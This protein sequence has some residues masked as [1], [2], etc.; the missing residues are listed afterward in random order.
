MA[1]SAAKEPAEVPE[2]PQINWFAAVR[3]QG[4]GKPLTVD[5]LASPEHPADFGPARGDGAEA[6]QEYARPQGANAPTWPI[7]STDRRRDDD[8]E[9]SIVL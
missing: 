1:N 4:G 5:G 7:G 9:R 3:H 6:N 8:G 2:D